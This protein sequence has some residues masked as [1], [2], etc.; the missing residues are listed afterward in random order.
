MNI[1]VK[2]EFEEELDFEPDGF[3]GDSRSQAMLDSQHIYSD[4]STEKDFNLDSREEFDS[5]YSGTE[6]TTVDYSISNVSISHRR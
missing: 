5:N 3:D 6:S 2:L 1:H 4:Q